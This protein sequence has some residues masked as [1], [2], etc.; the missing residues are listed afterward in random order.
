MKKQLLVT[1]MGLFLITGYYLLIPANA[2]TPA[3]V[4]LTWQA[5]NFYPANYQSKPL[6]SPNTPITVSAEVSNGGKLI[7]LSRA[8][9]IWYADGKIIGRGEGAKEATFNGQ[10]TDG[11]DYF[12]R[13][14]IDLNNNKFENSMRVPA[15]GQFIV[16]ESS[17]AEKSAPAGSQIF[18][19][20]I[21]YFFNVSSLEGLSFSW[22]I[23][24][25]QIDGG[26]QLAVNVG[27]PQTP[28]QSMVRINAFVQNRLNSLEFANAKTQLTVSK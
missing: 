8:N 1:I 13:V 12:V 24:E 23:N 21:P 14:V 18:L 9:F 26:N 10:K 17:A 7:D 15:V 2:Q 3:Q 27:L 28:E 4:I 20:I 5:N 19:Q 16:I 22:R 11:D 6:A 25:K